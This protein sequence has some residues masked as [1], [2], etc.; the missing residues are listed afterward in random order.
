MMLSKVT[1]IA[2]LN[3]AAAERHAR[4]I[5]VAYVLAALGITATGLGGLIAAIRGW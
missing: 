4:S 1:V 2:P 3:V 5:A